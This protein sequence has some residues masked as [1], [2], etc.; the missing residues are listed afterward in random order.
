MRRMAAVLVLG[1][2]L[3]LAGQAQAASPAEG[4]WRTQ[5]HNGEVKV[6]ACG[7]FLCG[8]IVTSERLKVEPD[9]KDVENKD[10]ALRGR[11]LKDLMFLSGFSGGP[12][13]WKGGRVYNPD[14]GGTYK[15]TI[16]LVDADTL[17]LTGCITWPL[18]KTQTWRRI[19]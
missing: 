11:L 4:R 1:L 15:G 16:K 8:Y 18:C 9:M 14:D 10:P 2:G 19:K 7:E 6:E 12:T 13:Q 3:A 5:S 17:K